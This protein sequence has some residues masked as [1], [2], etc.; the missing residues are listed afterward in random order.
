MQ[1]EDMWKYFVKGG[2][3]FEGEQFILV[4]SLQKYYTTIHGASQGV[5][6]HDRARHAQ[7][8]WI[9]S[10]SVYDAAMAKGE[11][12]TNSRLEPVVAVIV[13]N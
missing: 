9:E 6:I 8:E 11:R 3:N 1:S 4:L 12:T 13:S 2:V 10:S 5:P 7:H